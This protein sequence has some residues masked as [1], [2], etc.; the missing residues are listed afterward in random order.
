MNT[1]ETFWSRIGKGGVGECWRW[2]G[3]VDPWGYGVFRWTSRYG[4]KPLK[5]HRVSYELH[6]HVALPAGMVIMHTCDVRSCCNP[7]HLVL[8]THADNQRDMSAKGRNH[9]S[10]KTHCPLGHPY[11]EH[12][13]YWHRRPGGNFSRQCRSCGRAATARYQARRP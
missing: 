13:T 6:H 7:D 4:R 2:L 1:E 3:A 12:N 8:G 9:H 11:D 10:V 5:S